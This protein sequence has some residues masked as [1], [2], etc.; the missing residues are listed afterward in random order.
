MQPWQYEIERAGRSQR[1]GKEEISSY[2]A[3]CRE[4]EIPST[5]F[6]MNDNLEL[7]TLE[8]RIKKQVVGQDHVIQ[9]IVSSI[10]RSTI[11]LSKPTKPI[12][13]F[14]LVGDSW[15]GIDLAKTLVNELF[16]DE[17]FLIRIDMFAYSDRNSD[18]RLLGSLGQTGQLIEV[19]R[20]P[21]SIVLFENVEEASTAVL[22]IL[23]SIINFGKLSNAMGSEIDFSN[24]MV[25]MTTNIDLYN[26]KC[27]E[28]IFLEQVRNSIIQKFQTRF[29]ERMLQEMQILV[30][31]K[32]SM[33]YFRGIL[34]REI[35]Y[36]SKL[37]KIRGRSLKV[38]PEAIDA[39]L[40]SNI[41]K[42][43]DFRA[44]KKWLDDDLKMVL[45]RKILD[46]NMPPF[47]Q[48]NVGVNLEGKLQYDFA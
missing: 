24:T 19:C 42:P 5:Y 16:H 26:S 25:L 6:Q 1:E 45:A 12:G 43:V 4:S 38:T 3:I 17:S 40:T 7:R 32:P 39:I 34:E 30:F 48:I 18:S 11:G 13:S 21:F 31:D 9:P 14:L 20:R 44:I 10:L 29:S 15:M 36:I 8:E 28:E 46:V 22:N 2:E 27:G 37:M 23:C 33:E 35:F 41:P 47:S